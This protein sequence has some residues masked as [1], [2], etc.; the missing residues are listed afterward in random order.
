MNETEAP[1]PDPSWGPK[2]ALRDQ[3]LTA[4]R[5]MTPAELGVR[6]LAVAEVALSSPGVRRAATVMPRI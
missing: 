4:R 5:R 3:L 2:L 1:I 6:A